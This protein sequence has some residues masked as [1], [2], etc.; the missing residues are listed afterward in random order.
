MFYNP[1]GRAEVEAYL[2]TFRSSLWT[3]GSAGYDQKWETEG[4]G[5]VVKQE[6]PMQIRQP[7]DAVLRAGRRLRFRRRLHPN[8]VLTCRTIASGWIPRRSLGL[9]SK[10]ERGRGV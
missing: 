10:E 1:G 7:E 5:L 9:G 2:E 4:L 8:C 3:P 6:R